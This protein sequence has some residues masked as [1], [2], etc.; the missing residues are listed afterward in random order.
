MRSLRHVAGLVCTLCALAAPARSQDRL[1]LAE[2]ERAQAAALQA[3]RD[4]IAEEIAQ[5]LLR[6]VPPERIAA[7]A[8]RLAETLSAEQ[9]E[10][11]RAGKGLASVLAAEAG[12]EQGGL[13]RVTA[14]ALGDATADLVFVPVTPCRVIDT[15]LSPAG[16]LAA[17]VV[18]DFEIAGNANFSPQGGNAAGCGIP[19]GATLPLAS[20]VAINFVAVGPAGPGNLRAW[21]FGQPVPNAAVINYANVPGLNIAN[22]VI[23]PI[24]GVA[25]ADKDLHVRA[26]VSGT[27]L[28]ADV[29]GYFTRF[30]VEDLKSSLKSVVV[31]ASNGTV[32]ELGDGGC[33]ELTSCTVSSTVPGKVVIE[34]VVQVVVNHSSG[35]QDRFVMQLETTDP[36]TCPADESVDAA[37]YEIPAAL[38]TNADVDFTLPHGRTFPQASGTVTYRLSGRMV[39]GAGS[40]DQAENSRLICTFIPD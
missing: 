37:D 2:P 26:D 8:K 21:E 11:L 34:A 40:L 18:R 15:R 12:A 22:G 27:H 5:R 16:P 20:S 39:D 30:P 36:V 6:P 1:Q 17:G 32:L 7:D 24:A 14:K 13:S 31:Q 4:I 38:G 29:T 25:T 35:T 3:A 28:V 10:A 33:K 19:Q 23:V 9:V